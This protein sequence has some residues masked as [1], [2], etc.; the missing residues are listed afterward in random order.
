ME[1]ITWAEFKERRTDKKGF[2]LTHYSKLFDAAH[3][4]VNIKGWIFS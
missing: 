2:A 3:C 4:R 1:I